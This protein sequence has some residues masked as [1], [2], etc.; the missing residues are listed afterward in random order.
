MPA[1]AARP[2][3]RTSSQHHPPIPEHIRKAA[4]PPAN[5]P[6]VRT[7]PP[8][9]SHLPPLPRP[10]SH[11]RPCKGKPGKA[12]L[13]PNNLPRLASAPR[14]LLPSPALTGPAPGRQRS[15]PPATPLA[16]HPCGCFS[17]ACTASPSRSTAPAPSLA[18]LSGAPSQRSRAQRLAS[19]LGSNAARLHAQQAVRGVNGGKVN[20]LVAVLCML[21][22]PVHLSTQE[23][24]SAQAVT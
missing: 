8:F 5:K 21:P 11:E 16:Y 15:S 19:L 24:H 14:P 23:A 12:D 10:H 1:A 2:V 6:P 7:A 9:A 4:R 22:L 3:P 18:S 20:Q 13:R 17:H